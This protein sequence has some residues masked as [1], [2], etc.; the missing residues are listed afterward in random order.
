MFMRLP[1]DYKKFIKITVL[2]RVIPCAFLLLL[3][4]VV[5][6]LFGD[7]L[8]SSVDVE[9]FKISCYIVVLLLP[10]LIT[11]VPHKLIDRTYIGIVEDVEVTTTVGFSSAIGGRRG[12]AYDKN[13]VHLGIRTEDGK[14]IYRKVHD[15]GANKV[16]DMKF[17][18]YNIGDR[19]FHLYGSG[20]TIVVS[21]KPND[22]KECAVCGSI[23][24]P[25]HDK[26]R[27]CDHTILTFD[28]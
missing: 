28:I 5:L 22:A 9:E 7:R 4:A 2:K 18:K 19:V 10:F 8:F 6:I 20:C 16:N 24:A 1:E 11:G 26:C 27:Y 14:L 15:A 21:K 12:R 17:R 25:E 3:F 13:V 23:N